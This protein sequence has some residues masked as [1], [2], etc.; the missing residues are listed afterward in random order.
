MSYTIVYEGTIVSNNE[1]YAGVHWTKRNTIKNDYSLVFLNLLTRAKV[2]PFTQ[3]NL[4]I[5]FNSR[6]DCDNVVATAKIFID[7]LKGRYVKD[8]TKKFF[9]GFSVDYDPS[10]KKNTMVFDIIT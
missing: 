2:Q 5:R 4:K 7:T 10:L 6:H 9:K 1:F 8:D 3:F